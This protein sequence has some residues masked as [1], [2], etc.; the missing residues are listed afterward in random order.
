MEI[1]FRFDLGLMAKICMNK[2]CQATTTF[3]WKEGWGLNSGAFA[4]LC[5]NCGYKY[6]SSVSELISCSNPRALWGRGF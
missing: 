2:A 4:T 3:Q 6:I 5:F 1:C